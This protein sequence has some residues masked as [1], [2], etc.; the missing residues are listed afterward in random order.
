M[1]T[2]GFPPPWHDPTGPAIAQPPEGHSTSLRDTL[3][4]ANPCRS[5]A[6]M[7]KSQLVDRIAEQNRRLYQRDLENVVDAILDRIA[8]TLA[9][10]DRIELRGFGAFSVK[11]RRARD[12]RNPRTGAHIGSIGNRYRYS[13]PARK[14]TNAS[15]GRTNPDLSPPRAVAHRENARWLRRARCQRPGA[16]RHL[17]PGERSRS[18]AGESADGRRSCRIC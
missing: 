8:A 2:R 6:T 18:E 10:G 7:L 14:C 17:L 3:P 4:L 5:E 11:S 13:R 9:R 15:M 12:G 16:C 1:A